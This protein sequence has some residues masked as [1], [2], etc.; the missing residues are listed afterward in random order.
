[1]KTQRTKK[2]NIEEEKEKSKEKKELSLQETPEENEETLCC[3]NQLTVLAENYLG[4]RS[5]SVIDI[6]E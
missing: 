1:M 6:R 4:L 2:Q 5:S 3:D